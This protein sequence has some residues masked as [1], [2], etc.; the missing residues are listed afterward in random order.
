MLSALCC[1]TLIS[2]TKGQDDHENDNVGTFADNQKIVCVSNT[3]FNSVVV[4]SFKLSKVIA[5]DLKI[6]KEIKLNVDEKLQSAYKATFLSLQQVVSKAGNKKNNPLSLNIKIICWNEFDELHADLPVEIQDNKEAYLLQVK[7]QKVNIYA[8][9]AAGVIHGISSLEYL[10]NK[11][12]GVIPNQ[13]IADWPD[14]DYRGVQIGLRGTT[15]QAAIGAIDRIRRAHYNYILLEIGNNVRFPS[16]GRLTNN[17]AWSIKE[18]TDVVKYA[19][20]SGIE[21]V[22][23][24]RLLTHQH[25]EF[26]V[27]GAYPELMYDAKTYDPRKEE[28]YKIV[29][30]YIDEIV[31]TI[32]PKAIHIG[33]DE[34][35][36]YGK[37]GSDIGEEGALPPELFKNHVIK[38]NNYLKSKNVK[39]WM[40]SDMLITPSEFPSM[41]SGS[42]NGTKEFAALRK[43]IPKD[44]VMCAW[45]Y[46]DESP[47]KNKI[48]EFPSMKMFAEEGFEVIGATFRHPHVAKAF[49]KYAVGL[50]HR[51]VKGMM[52]TTWFFFRKGAL[53]N[54]KSDN[55]KA[56]D[57]VIEVSSEAM[58]NAKK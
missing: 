52:A 36:G 4:P 30:A 12:N 38:I 23:A 49:P 50:N 46:R 13:D 53:D 17:C 54:N 24:L 22:P 56:F 39:T 19:Q 7:D 8:T 57:E 2:I 34:A 6:G 1:I 27:T 45:H 51:N 40:W 26:F 29:F 37:N 21:I 44:I 16:L 9:D 35:Y 55:W 15:P 11:N 18:F 47:D 5:G 58:W 31:E 14:I 33:H 42:I 3:V 41:H 32:N 43:D 48:L 25:K 28:V 10:I 20:E